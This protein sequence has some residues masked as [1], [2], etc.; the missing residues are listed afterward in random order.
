MGYDRKSYSPLEQIDKSNVHRLVPIWNTSLMNLSGELAA[1]AIYGGVLY[2]IN[3]SWTFAIDLTTGR[4]LWRTPVVL[5]EGA[6]RRS[7]FNRGGPVIYE[8]RIFRVT[9]DNHI[10]ALD[11]ETGEELGTGSSP[12]RPRATTRRAR[13]SSPTGC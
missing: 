11:M 4:Q 6:R 1:P 13:R 10:L 7:T 5:E 3:G 2:A 8:G 9:V 12:T